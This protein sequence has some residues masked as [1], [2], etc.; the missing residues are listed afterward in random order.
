M[1]KLGRVFH[2]AIGR[3]VLV[4]GGCEKLSEMGK[5]AMGFTC[6]CFKWP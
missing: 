5:M 1:V 2:A 3:I 4:K 6:I